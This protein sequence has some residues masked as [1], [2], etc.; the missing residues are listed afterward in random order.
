MAHIL[1]PTELRGWGRN[2][3]PDGGLTGVEFSARCPPVIKR[4]TR[5]VAV[6]GITDFQD[7]SSPTNDGWFHSDFYLFHHLYSGLSECPFVPSPTYRR[8]S[9][10]LLIDTS[11]IWLTCVDPAHLVT[12][13]KESV[14][15]NRSE[16]RRVVLDAEMLPD[17]Q[18]AGNI[19]VVTANDLLERF[20][21][22]VRAECQIARSNQESV[23]ILIFGHG[24]TGSYGVAIGGSRATATAPRLQI[25][26]MRIAIGNTPNVALVMTSCYS[27]GWVIKETPDRTKALN[28]TM[29]TAAGPGKFSESWAKSESSGRAAGSIFASALVKAAIKMQIQDEEEDENEDE[30]TSSSAYV[31]WA[32]LICD[33]GRTEVD[34]LF[35]KHDVRFSAQDDT[36]DAEWRTVSAIQMADYKAKWESLKS[37]PVD[38]SNPITNRAPGSGFEVATERLSIGE[39]GSVTIGQEFP[40]SFMNI[41]REQARQYV[42]SFPGNDA[43]GCNNHHGTFQELARGDEFDQEFSNDREYLGNLSNELCYRRA[44]MTLATNYKDYLELEIAD[45]DLFDTW[46]WQVKILE[47]CDINEPDQ[48]KAREPWTRYQKIHSAIHD[49]GIFPHPAPGQ[50]LGYSKPSEYLAIAFYDSGRPEA[51]ILDEIQKLA[52]RK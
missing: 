21:S 2:A 22:T 10:N 16:M 35:W 47:A 19:R 23:L 9:A 3:G 6:C 46:P 25:E 51:Q 28:A 26:S 32:K 48:R 13:Y 29:M 49:A 17:I 36:W 40:G 38:I 37:I 30:I 11:Q 34:R 8:L 31:G 24:D 1:E 42:N 41:L 15:G 14:H 45:G 18:K 5:I 52:R 43:G 27:G 12:Q 7:A 20:L 50:G 33:T 39:S 44:L 4:R